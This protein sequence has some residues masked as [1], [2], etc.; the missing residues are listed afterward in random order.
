MCSVHTC[1][2]LRDQ[3]GIEEQ[4]CEIKGVSPYNAVGRFTSN[5]YVELALRSEILFVFFFFLFVYAKKAFRSFSEIRNV[6][7]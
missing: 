7:F 6:V 3:G 1:Q 4:K 5:S 2:F